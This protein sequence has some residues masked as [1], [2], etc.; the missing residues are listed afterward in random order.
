MHEVYKNKGDLT[1]G[2]EPVD[3]RTFGGVDFNW[4]EV[5]S[6]KVRK[7]NGQ[8][9]YFIEFKTGVTARYPLQENGGASISSRELT[10]WQSMDYDTETFLK[11]MKHAVIKG[12]KKDDHIVAKGITNSTIDV[13]QDD[14]DDHV[15]V[16]SERTYAGN[17][18]LHTEES[19]DNTVILDDSDSATKKNKSIKYKAG[20]GKTKEEKEKDLFEAKGQG[21][22]NRF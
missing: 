2:N 14:N 4:N 6:A 1:M 22:D 9:I 20:G 16:I 7:V 8:K 17:E 10:M 18:L 15:D 12:S 11:N 5:K 21:V 19:Y 3:N 13:S